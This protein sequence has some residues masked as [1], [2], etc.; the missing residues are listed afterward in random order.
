M[1]VVKIFSAFIE[2][3]KLLSFNYVNLRGNLK[4]GAIKREYQ[5]MVSK[6]IERE[7]T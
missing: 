7:R 2:F 1:L 5:R 4:N 3:I 6:N